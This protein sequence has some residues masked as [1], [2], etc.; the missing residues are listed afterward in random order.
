MCVIIL[1]ISMYVSNLD[2]DEFQMTQTL[3]NSY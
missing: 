1:P 3:L 2:F